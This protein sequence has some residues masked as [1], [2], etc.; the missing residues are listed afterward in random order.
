MRRV[1]VFLLMALGAALPS[2]AFAKK[3]A[4]VADDK[5]NCK[6]ITGRMQVRIM[7]I[8]GHEEKQQ[9]TGLSRGI[10][11]GFVATFGNLAHG[12]DPEGTYAAGLKML[13][14]YN[15]RLA[16]MGCKSYDLN[17]ELNQKDKNETPTP[18]VPPPKKDKA[19]VAPA[20]K[21]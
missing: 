21:N 15:Q 6:Q 3:Q 11:S 2:A 19:Q 5:L 16:A 4:P 12:V 18:T 14:D 17:F 9:S 1:T 13:S 20:P 10:Q 8:R 7:E